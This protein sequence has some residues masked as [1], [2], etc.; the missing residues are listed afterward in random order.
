VIANLAMDCWNRMGVQGDGSCPELKSYIHCRNCPVF[1]NAGRT[2][3]DREPPGDYLQEQTDLLS[4]EKETTVWQAHAV[5][6]FR[7]QGE[8]LALPARLLVEI[9]GV[10]PIRTIP[11][12][13][14]DILLGLVKVRGEIHLAFSLANLLGIEAPAAQSIPAVARS[15]PRFV[16]VKWNRC[17]WVFPADAVRGLHRFRAEEVQPK[18]STVAKALPTFTKGLLSL[19]GSQVGLLDE[20]LLFQALER[21]IS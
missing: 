8:W 18:P 2:L 10:C 3:L 4:H 5:T 11:H 20:D 21:S 7:V 14:N 9:V 19:E 17:T 13:T 15:L 12:R 16:V 6:V 1:E